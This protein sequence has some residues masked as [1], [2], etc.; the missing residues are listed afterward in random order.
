MQISRILSALILAL[1]M[2]LLTACAG[3]TSVSP[4]EQASAE[5]STEEPSKQK[6]SEHTSLQ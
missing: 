1:L 6:E 5:A 2:L 3:N 4:D